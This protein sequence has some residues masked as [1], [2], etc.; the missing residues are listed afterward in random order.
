MLCSRQTHLIV[1]LSS[2]CLSEVVCI[3]LI[4]ENKIMVINSIEVKFMRAA[5]EK[6]IINELGHEASTHLNITCGVS[7]G[8][9]PQGASITSLQS[10]APA[11][12]VKWC[13]MREADLILCTCLLHIG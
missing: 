6:L 5:D 1:L 4:C 7:A 13:C 9:P 8:R 11:Y 10:F 3:S 12:T 2:L